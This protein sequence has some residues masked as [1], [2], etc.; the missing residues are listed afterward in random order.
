MTRWSGALPWVLVAALGTACVVVLGVLSFDP[1]PGPAQTALQAQPDRGD[2][3][4]A[5][6]APSPTASPLGTATAPPSGTASPSGSA[7]PASPA[8]PTGPS[9]RATPRPTPGDP[10]PGGRPATRLPTPATPFG[11]TTRVCVPTPRVT[12]LKVAT[13]NIHGGLGPRGRD[14]PQVVAEIR[15][16]GADV[17]MLQEVDRFRP[18]SGGIDMPAVLGAELGMEHAFAPN[19][20]HGG[21]AEYG[22]AT[23]S[24][25]PILDT[26]HVLLP[27]DPGKEQRGV[28]RTRLAVGPEEVDVYNTHLD[29]TSDPLRRRQADQV[30]V[31]VERGGAPVVLGGDF[32]ASPV[33]APYATLTSAL[34]DAWLQVGVGR[35][36]TAGRAPGARID[37][38]FLHEAVVPRAA[39]VLPSSVS[40]HDAVVVDTLVAGV[41]PCEWTSDRRA[42]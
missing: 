18:R 37:Y 42:P 25:F 13:F 10:S 15:A 11:A 31:L 2:R 3:G 23:L 36:P 38:V 4:T 22:V 33:T 21:R 7:S 28:L 1:A 17:V 20:R 14:L 32:N 24:R 5:T 35:G 26:E 6:V 30:R 41:S 27:N 19:V 16:S 9:G 12:P 40:D 8:A 34:G 29:H 39:R